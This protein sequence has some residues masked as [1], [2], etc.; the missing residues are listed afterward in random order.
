[1]LDIN[2]TRT[3]HVILGDVYAHKCPFPSSRRVA[4]QCTH[5]CERPEG[6]SV[7]NTYDVLR[8]SHMPRPCN[9]Y[10]CRLGRV[11][12]VWWLEPS[13]P[14]RARSTIVLFRAGTDWPSRGQCIPSGL[15]SVESEPMAV[16]NVTNCSELNSFWIRD[17]VWTF[18][19][20]DEAMHD[21]S[22]TA[23]LIFVVFVVAV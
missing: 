15:V 18:P 17:H 3:C 5:S 9:W 21:L 2:C 19:V 20:W 11:D 14:Y 23:E 7:D 12:R 1:M 13:I 22:T 4:V 16:Q 10:C 8:M 6:P